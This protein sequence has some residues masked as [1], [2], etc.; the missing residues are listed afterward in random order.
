MAEEVLF[1]CRRC[2]RSFPVKRMDVLDTGEDPSFFEKVRDNSAFWVQCPYCGWE[3]HGDYSFLYKERDRHYMLYY[4]ADEE[5]YRRIFGIF[6]KKSGSFAGEELSRWTK[7][8]VTYHRDV[9]EKLLILDG[10][11]DDRI[12]EIMKA[13]AY[14]SLH[15]QRKE[16]K[17]DTVLFDRGADGNYYFRFLEGK[18]TAAAYAFERSMYEKIREGVQPFLNGADGDS[19]VVNSQWAVQ[20]LVRMQKG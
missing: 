15:R 16:L 2:G 8:I 4:A 3:T 10:G 19:P 11:M 7:R 20:L 9:L 17:P 13:L 1:P 6:R 5:D 14:A 18:E 12:I